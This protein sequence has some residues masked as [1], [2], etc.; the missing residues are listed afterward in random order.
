MM[1]E[2]QATALH[3]QFSKRTMALFCQTV[4]A[5]LVLLAGPVFAQE[6][7]AGTLKFYKYIDDNHGVIIPVTDAPESYAALEEIVARLEKAQHELAPDLSETGNVI[8]ILDSPVINAFVTSDK[9]FPGGVK[10]NLIFITKGIIAEM[11]KTSNGDREL[12]LKRIIGIL[13]HEMAH[14]VDEVAPD[15]ISQRGGSSQSLELRVDMDGA[16]MARAAQLPHDAVFQT[17]LALGNNIT[18]EGYRAAVEAAVASHPQA[19]LRQGVQRVFLTMDRFEHGDASY[20]PLTHD[21]AK[22]PS[23]LAPLTYPWDPFH[24]DRYRKWTAVDIP[25]ILSDML[26]ILD[27]KDGENYQVLF[28]FRLATLNDLLAKNPPLDDRLIE[29]ISSFYADYFTARGVAHTEFVFGP[30][31]DTIHQ[32]FIGG[33]RANQRARRVPLYKDP[34]FIQM[35]VRDYAAKVPSRQAGASSNRRYELFKKHNI[36]NRMAVSSGVFDQ[37]GFF[38]AF[39]GYMKGALENRIETRSWDRLALDFDGMFEGVPDA[40]RLKYMNYAR[41][42]L[43]E[44]MNLTDKVVLTAANGAKDW[45]QFF[46]FEMEKADADRAGLTKEMAE[47]FWKNRGAYALADIFGR[48][49]TNRWANV[50][51]LLKIDPKRGYEEIRAAFKALTQTADYVQ[52]L[53]D[54]PDQRLEF[55]VVLSREIEVEWADAQ[56]LAYAGDAVAYIF[57][58]RIPGGYGR[59]QAQQELMAEIQ[60]HPRMSHD[61]LLALMDKIY[62]PRGYDGPRDYDGL[63]LAIRNSNLDVVWKRYLLDEAF[64]IFYF[65]HPNTLYAGFG[66]EHWIHKTEGGNPIVQL[67]LETGTIKQTTDIIERM[68]QI[69]HT[70][71]TNDGRPNGL[72]DSLFNTINLL[73]HDLRAQLAAITKKADLIKF[74]KLAFDAWDQG[75]YKDH[76]LGSVKIRMREMRAE[77]IAKAAQLR[78]NQDE[79]K[80]LF[81]TLTAAGS[82]RATDAYFK[83]VASLYNASEAGDALVKKRFVSSR[84]KVWALEAG[85]RA[86]VR[87]LRGKVDANKLYELLEEAKKL[88]PEN[89][90]YKDEYIES[91]AWKLNIDDIQLL[92]IVDGYKSSSWKSQDGRPSEFASFFSQYLTEAKPEIRELLIRYFRDPKEGDFPEALDQE[93][94]RIVSPQSD[95]DSRDETYSLMRGRLE[96]FALDLTTEERVPILDNLLHE[97]GRSPET[98]VDYQKQIGRKYLGFLPDSSQEIGLLAYLQIVPEYE[99]TLTM[100]Y[101]LS[102]SSEDSGSILPIFEV[103]QAVGKKVGQY[104]ATWKVFSPEITEE[105]QALKERAKPLSK[106]QI[107]KMLKERLTPEEL[108]GLKVVRVLGAASVKVVVEVQLPDGSSAVAAIR[109]PDAEA[110]TDSNLNRASDY[111]GTLLDKLPGGLGSIM[112]QFVGVAGDQLKGEFTFSTEAA[113]LARAGA[114]YQ[115]LN[116][117]SDVRATGWKFNVPK[118]DPRFQVRDDMIFMEKVN[119][120]GFHKLTDAKVKATVGELIVKSSLAGLF[121]KGIFDADRH[122]GN[123]LIDVATKT[124][125]Q[126]DF[127]QLTEN[128]IKSS[129]WSR[130][131]RYFLA[132]FLWAIDRGDSAMSFEMAL[133]LAGLDT[134][135]PAERKTRVQ[136]ALKNAFA[137]SGEFDAK[138][139]AFVR[140]M[141]DSGVELG[142]NFLAGT[143]KGLLTL[144]GE[145][146]VTEEQFRLML[147]G[148]V[149]KV[150]LEKLPLTVLD[151]A[152]S[153]VTCDR[154]L[155]RGK[156]HE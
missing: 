6:M 126:F 59:L 49:E 130:D 70:G 61:E 96:Q 89:S 28:N 153:A 81:L 8:H 98:D 95:E 115:G 21:L 41:T 48:Y 101:I 137:E 73:S 68:N 141:G 78:L 15:S 75:Y 60:K 116:E 129:P 112:R 56:S 9:E 2:N 93:I 19:D 25:Q 138:L 26:A 108:K 27:R 10:K 24:M 156:D 54:I 88:V 58:T 46:T 63:A 47:H 110:V 143:L 43:V 91:L 128:A 74:A 144:K 5:S 33:K 17:L 148:Y 111:L 125:H 120:T 57:K 106:F 90:G 18:S 38:E 107:L 135:I 150:L 113:A 29:S 71:Y 22:I 77:V 132:Q 134:K 118:L 53:K 97:P 151:R 82:T 30:E 131:D 35:L 99:R 4:L 20:L 45:G 109:F 55:D 121:E 85:Q 62:K 152:R 127:G 66:F 104:A 39:D 114:F 65:A 36:L 139:M 11:W 122:R 50:F 117:R 102:Y 149:K 67:M 123:I 154:L 52:F 87:A 13:A 40:L 124:I 140:V 34:K 23:E 146:Y 92:Q 155:I 12:F 142:Q 69:N 31:Q 145:S 16:K 32:T 84:L 14:P 7:P 44:R 76:G 51:R 133:H 147:S 1:I 80:Q 64:L 105:L 37:A 83:T 42:V 3:R 136:A 100:A 86:K 119:G 103:F 94:R 79:K 72:A